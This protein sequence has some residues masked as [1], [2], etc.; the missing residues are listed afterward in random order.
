M[1]PL[2]LN[3][4]LSPVSAGFPSPAEDYIEDELDLNNYLIRNPPATFI[5]RVSGDSMTGAGIHSG[6]LLLVDRSLQAVSGHIIVAALDGELTVKRL[7]QQ[8]GCYW[9]YPENP[10]YAPIAAPDDLHIWGVAT[11]VIHRLC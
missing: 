3:L 1:K 5:V 7:Y 9:L 6:D 8:D 4:Y 2:I 10:S 11:T